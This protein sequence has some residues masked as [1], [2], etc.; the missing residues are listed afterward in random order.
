M[1]EFLM[2][3]RLKP[4][5]VCLSSMFESRKYFFNKDKKFDLHWKFSSCFDVNMFMFVRCSKIDV[6]VLSMFEKMVFNPLLFM[7]KGV[8][9]KEKEEKCII[10][11]EEIQ[12]IYVTITVPVQTPHLLDFNFWAKSSSNKSCDSFGHA[13]F[14]SILDFTMSQII[15]KYSHSSLTSSK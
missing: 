15:F 11:K 9:M 14:L 6:R 4:K 7:R 3:D 13:L 2:L 12:K 8:M 1:F 10:E 5:M